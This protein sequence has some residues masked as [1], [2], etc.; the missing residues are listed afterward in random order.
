MHYYQFTIIN[1]HNGWISCQVHKYKQFAS[2]GHMRRYLRGLA[3]LYSWESV[4]SIS[5]SQYHALR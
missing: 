1:G 5:A 2:Q 4:D 3:K